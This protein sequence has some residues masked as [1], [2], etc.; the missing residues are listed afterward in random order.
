V[1]L[2]LAYTPLHHL[3]L[4]QA[5]RPLVMTSGNL[6]DEP[7]AIANRE[8]LRRLE[9][10]ADLFLLHDRG[11]AARC[12]DSVAQVVAGAPMVLRRSRGYVPRAITLARPV[13]RPILATGAHLKNTFC[14]AAR[15]QAWLGPHIG[16]LDTLEAARAYE[17]AVEDMLRF[18][19]VRPEVVAHDLHP[20]YFTTAYAAD[21]PERDR[22]AVQHHHAH[23]A[24][25]LA[26]HG[27]AGPVLGVAFDG[28]GY[29]TD[30]GAW[31]G[32]FLWATA[33][34]FERIATLRPLALAGGEAALRQVW[35][36]ALALVEDALGRE[37]GVARYPVFAGVPPEEMAV[38]RQLLRGGRAV[39]AHGAGRYFDAVGSLVLG[40]PRSAFEGQ[41][42]LAWNV[43]ADG[44]RDGAYPFV[45]DDRPRPWEVDLRPTTRG[46]LDDL[47]A[48]VA[49]AVISCRFHGTLARV[50]SRVAERIRRERGTVPVVLT[51]GCFANR[52]LVERT[53]AAL[54]AGTDVRVHREVPPG[55]G[56]LA[57]GQVLVADAAVRGGAAP[58]AVPVLAAQ[59]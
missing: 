51:G 22:V 59:E 29:G 58:S 24:S 4:Q 3:L 5:G 16:D 23:V 42:A 35:R 10:I 9:G 54:G 31:G 47:H 2:L 1:G 27:L 26:E 13:A 41:V 34:S 53:L 18:T 20:D 14:I 15:D 43:A 40:R 49:P 50:V 56:G 6:S 25:A 33:G 12:D 44:A 52:L 30:G 55:D 37:A 38:V 45:V 32:E 21:R 28:T 48:G 36:L 39:R 8:A 19:G 46:V 7:M 11:I 57:L 17:G